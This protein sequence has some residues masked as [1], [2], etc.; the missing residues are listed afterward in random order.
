MLTVEIES[1]PSYRVVPKHSRHRLHVFMYLKAPHRSTHNLINSSTVKI[2]LCLPVA[3]TE[4]HHQGYPIPV[5]AFGH[6]GNTQG[7]RTNFIYSVGLFGL[8]IYTGS[9]I[10]Q[11]N[12]CNFR[13]I[14]HTGALRQSPFCSLLK[15]Y[16]SVRYIIHWWIVQNTGVTNPTREHCNKSL[17]EVIVVYSTTCVKLTKF[18]LK[19]F[20]ILLFT[21][22]CI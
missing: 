19:C 2:Y 3:V 5:S 11:V 10:G 14:Y 22:Y 20:K 18:P 8:T 16:Y 6:E 17:M 15:Q 9:L 4:A 7:Q 13:D 12:A 1:L 21:K